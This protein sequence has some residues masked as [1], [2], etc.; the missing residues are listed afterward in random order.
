MKKKSLLW[1]I[2]GAQLAAPSYIF[3]TMHVQDQRAFEGIEA[4]Y[5]CIDETE[6]FAAEYN[7]NEQ[8]PHAFQK[9]SQLPEGQSISGLLNPRIY[10][11]LAKVFERETGEDL[12]FFDQLKPAMIV[13]ILS[14][15]Q[16][17]EDHHQALDQMLFSYAAAE[18]KELLGLESF[19]RQMEIMDE[20]PLSDQ[21]RSLK[22][23]ATNFKNF[24]KNIKR[25]AQLYLEGDVQKILQNVK[26][27]TG[28]MRKL[29]LYDRNL[30]M[31]DRIDEIIREKP[32]FAA[33]GAG[34]LGGGKGIIHL[35]NTKGYRVNAVVYK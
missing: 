20:M 7:L 9:A 16:F 3:G 32:L 23:L 27:S 21:L 14:T 35:L 24:R 11:K 18:E 31:A 10:K 19:E 8:D 26:A 15:A 28:K 4:I 6:A 5:H 34:H 30:I 22:S 1:K 2:E 33:V 13:N 12:E 29:L 17:E 25:T